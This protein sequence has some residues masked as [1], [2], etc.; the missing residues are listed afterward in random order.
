MFCR[1]VIDSTSQKV[2]RLIIESY[3]A[4]SINRIYAIMNKET[5]NKGKK[6]LSTDK[7]R[8]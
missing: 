2:C 3:I 1:N 7:A 4:A 6:V 8:E 5:T